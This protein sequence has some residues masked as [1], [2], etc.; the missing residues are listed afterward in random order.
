MRA[1]CGACSHV[2][3]HHIWLA[4]RWTDCDH[5]CRVAAELAEEKAV[6]KGPA[7]VRAGLLDELYLLREEDVMSRVRVTCE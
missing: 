7:S 6:R 1:L 3:S 2:A 4:V 5:V